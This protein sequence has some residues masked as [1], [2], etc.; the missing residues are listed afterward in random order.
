MGSE[1]V[2][3]LKLMH[4]N[5]SGKFQ[6]AWLSCVD[7]IQNIGIG[8]N[9]LKYRQALVSGMCPQIKNLLRRKRVSNCLAV[10]T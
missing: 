1:L 6:Y 8:T 9:T 3:G 2:R 5:Q 4:Q 7:G 10:K